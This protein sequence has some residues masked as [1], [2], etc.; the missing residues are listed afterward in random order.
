MFRSV[1]I[2]LAKKFYPKLKFYTYTCI[3]YIRLLVKKSAFIPYMFGVNTRFY[4]G[5]MFKIFFFKMSLTKSWFYTKGRWL[6]EL[7]SSLVPIW[8]LSVVHVYKFFINSLMENDA[9]RS[10]FRDE[11]FIFYQDFYSICKGWALW[12]SHFSYFMFKEYFSD[13]DQYYDIKN[14]T[15]MYLFK[16][17]GEIRYLYFI[18]II[19]TWVVHSSRRRRFKV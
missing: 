3:F 15:Y 2:I 12:F 6:S 19:K 17:Y 5:L 10:Y 1:L 14:K 9:V 8:F 18:I 16:I 4:G 13:L 11:I 7:P